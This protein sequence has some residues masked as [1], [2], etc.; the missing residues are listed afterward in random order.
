MEV[1]MKARM[2][3]REASYG[4]TLNFGFDQLWCTRREITAMMGKGFRHLRK[5]QEIEIELTAKV[6]KKGK[7]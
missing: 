6:V 2:Y 7:K 3:K 1:S 5:G 4:Y